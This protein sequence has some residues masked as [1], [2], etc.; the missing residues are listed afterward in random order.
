MSSMI[1]WLRSKKKDDLVLIAY[2]LHVENR[3]LTETINIGVEEE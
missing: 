3:R 2:K 1:K